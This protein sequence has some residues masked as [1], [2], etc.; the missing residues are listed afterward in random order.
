MAPR[1]RAGRAAHLWR[2]VE[3]KGLEDGATQEDVSLNE[4]NTLV[5]GEVVS[6]RRDGARAHI[7]HGLP[8]VCLRRTLS[9]PR[10]EAALEIVPRLSRRWTRTAKKVVV[11]AQHFERNGLL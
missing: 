1:L 5:R 6:V 3:T 9:V 10:S 8:F 2:P 4:R 11:V 7:Q